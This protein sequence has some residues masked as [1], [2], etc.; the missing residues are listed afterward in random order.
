MLVPTRPPIH[1]LLFP[2]PA[3]FPDVIPHYLR[4]IP[5][6]KI[7]GRPM[8]DIG[9][10]QAIHPLRLLKYIVERSCEFSE[11]VQAC[12]NPLKPYQVIEV[13]CFLVI[14]SWKDSPV[15]LIVDVQTLD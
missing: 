14:P 6:G 9:V 11:S 1:L 4:L 15:L 13:A 8:E 10:K 3:M 2:Q 7:N 12:C 5:M